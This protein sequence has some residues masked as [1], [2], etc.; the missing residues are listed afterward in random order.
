MASQDDRAARRR[1]VRAVFDQLIGASK[2]VV[3]GNRDL[4]EYDEDTEVVY[5]FF[6]GN[7]DA[8]IQQW[9]T[10]SRRPAR[11]I[12]LDVMSIVMAEQN[13]DPDLHEQIEEEKED[14]PEIDFQSSD[15]RF[16]RRLLQPSVLAAVTG[17]DPGS[18]AVRGVIQNVI[19]DPQ[20][21]LAYRLLYR[22]RRPGF[23]P[24]AAWDP[25]GDPEEIIRRRQRRFIE[26]HGALPVEP[27]VYRTANYDGLPPRMQ[28]WLAY[29]LTHADGNP[30]RAAAMTRP[31]PR[32]PVQKTK[33]PKAASKAKAKK[34]KPKRRAKT[35]KT[36][37]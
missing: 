12:P 13:R 20:S 35:A 4:S 18:A 19:R 32:K 5:H 22:Q 11:D 9:H 36:V 31:R 17:Q 3:F 21:D 8:V 16:F 29:M 27:R 14:N 1:A 10:I 28:D 37:T 6:V 30:P 24:A 7:L 23:D 15:L 25:Q 26:E 33:T 2:Q 34:P